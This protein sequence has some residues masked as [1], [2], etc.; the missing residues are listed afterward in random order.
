MIS[1]EKQDI[2][3]DKL[4]YIIKLQKFNFNNISK[5]L[6]LLNFKLQKI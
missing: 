1:Y 2:S 5:L 6:K 4:K 3:T